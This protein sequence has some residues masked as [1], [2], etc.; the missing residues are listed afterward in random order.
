[1]YPKSVIP[2]EF[3]TSI[4]CSIVL[5]TSVA[6]VNANGKHYSLSLKLFFL[7]VLPTYT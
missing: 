4:Y 6:G 1:M 3:N 7:L 5:G 2:I